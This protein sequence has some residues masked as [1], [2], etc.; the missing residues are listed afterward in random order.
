[1]G[2]LAG[3]STAPRNQA[4]K[5]PQTDDNQLAEKRK[6]N[7]PSTRQERVAEPQD[8][9]PG[10]QSDDNAGQASS[11][12][13][14]RASSEVAAGGLGCSDFAYYKVLENGGRVTRHSIRKEE[15]PTGGNGA[16]QQFNKA[17]RQKQD[18]PVKLR[19]QQRDM[20]KL[21]RRPQSQKSQASQ[22]RKPA[23][24]SSLPV[25]KEEPHN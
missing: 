4:K 8:E 3:A 7:A 17:A 5:S 1:M 25:Q 14:G 20:K 24:A 21:Q 23:A 6:G 19:P 2:S 16:A 9:E 22:N 13:G 15:E 12:A 11:A 10:S 18:E